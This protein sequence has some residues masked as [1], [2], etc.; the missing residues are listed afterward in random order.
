[1]KISLQLRKLATYIHFSAYEA[2]QESDIIYSNGPNSQMAFPSPPSKFDSQ[3]CTPHRSFY[4]CTSF[5]GARRIRVF[6]ARLLDA[7]RIFHLVRAENLRGP[8]K[9]RLLLQHWK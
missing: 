7:G 8:L 6:L 9:V 5:L 2:F 1:M 3:T 4:I